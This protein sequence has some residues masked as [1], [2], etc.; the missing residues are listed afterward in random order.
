[1]HPL[2][3]YLIWPLL[4]YVAYCCILFLIQR[5]IM[6]PRSLIPKPSPS[7]QEVPG[8]EQ[9]WLHTEFGKV[10][11]WFLPPTI[12]NTFAPAPA[13]IFAHGNGELIDFL[14]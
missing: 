5:Q 10:E 8:L 1:M 13:V 7:M 9:I 3:K 14:A 2:L 6:F 4:L 12:E 11:S